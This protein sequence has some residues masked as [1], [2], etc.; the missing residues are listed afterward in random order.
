MEAVRVGELFLQDKTR[1]NEGASLQYFET[2]PGLIFA[3][4]D[5][6]EKEVEGLK[7]GRAKFAVYD[8]WPVVLFLADIKGVGQAD[9]PLDMRL[10]GERGYALLPH[11]IPEG[12]GLMLWVVLVDARTGI[13]RAQRVIGLEHDFSEH[14]VG[15]L[16]RQLDSP[17][18]PAEFGTKLDEIYAKYSYKHLAVLGKQ[19]K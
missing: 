5:P 3:F 13:L 6:S 15:L 18:T 14:L 10:Y 1:Y 7:N 2:G 9:C 17:F 11:V 16:R 8:D 4:A 19:N 12:K